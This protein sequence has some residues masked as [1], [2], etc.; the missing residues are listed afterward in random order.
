MRRSVAC[1]VLAALLALSL[2][3]P[4]SAAP[5]TLPLR[6]QDGFPDPGPPP[7]VAPAWTL[8]D[9]GTGLLLADMAADEERAIASVTKIMTA[10]V[11]LER[12]SLDELVTISERAASTGE[13]EI[14]LVPGEQI[15]LDALLKALLVASAND[16]ATAIAEH[17]A[18]SVSDFVVLMNQKADE[19]GLT[20]TRFAN[21]HGLD[22]PNHYSSAAD[23]VTLTMAAMEHPEFRDAV[24]SQV[25]VFPDAPDGTR[26]IAT[27]TNLLLGAYAGAVG[28]K[29]G[30][31]SRAQLTFVA[32]AERQGRTLYAVVLGSEG[33]RAHFAD[34]S[35]L[36]D[37]GFGEKGILWTLLRGAPYTSMVERAGPEPLAVQAGV[38]ALLSVTAPEVAAE[39][40]TMEV[41]PPESPSVAITRIPAPGPGSLMDAARF[42]LRGLWGG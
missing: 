18:G 22:A 19:L 29:T 5:L 32:V 26:R 21:P 24:R 9:A 8:Y 3:A 39:P 14:G 15:T 33:N 4:A 20:N 34:A 27:T 30:F 28:V 38:E 13:K 6:P 40:A 17:V 1:A 35:A 23:L 42:W 12:A 11:A 7:L 16:A 31:T 2:A 36:L 25:L 37:Y 41:A 10:L